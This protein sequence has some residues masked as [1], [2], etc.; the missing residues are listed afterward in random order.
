MIQ[1]N[2]TLR[3][4]QFRNL[5]K[6]INGLMK[7]QRWQEL[8]GE[9][10]KQ[11]TGRLHKLFR[12]INSLFTK[13]EL[14]K[15]L[16]GAAVLLGLS[17]NMQAQD[18]AAPL[19]NP[20]NLAPVI[21]LSIPSLV[22]ID[23]DGDLD[24]FVVEYGYSATSM[25]FFRNEGTAANPVFGK[26]EKN[27]F[28]FA[29]NSEYYIFPAFADLDDDGDQDI[30]SVGYTY[31][32]GV[33]IF[34]H[35]N[36]GTANAPAF[37]PEQTNPFGVQL[38]PYSIQPAMADIDGDGDLDLLIGG[39]RY[40]Y[41]AYEYLGELSYFEN[42]GTPAAAN[43]AGLVST[44]VDTSPV[45]YFVF[46]EFGDLDGDGDMDILTGSYYGSLHYFEN[47]GSTMMPAFGA[48]QT[49]PFNLANPSTEFTLPALGDIDDDGDLDLFVGGYYGNVEFYENLDIDVS[50]DDPEDAPGFNIFPSPAD[51]LLTIEI[52]DT[53][54]AEAQLS[55]F[56]ELG[57][58]V[59]AELVNTTQKTL[60]IGELPA[61]FYIVKIQTEERQMTRKL[62]IQ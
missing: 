4:R 37:G 8:T 10:R 9:Q 2:Y 44:L 56:N 21:D 32:T 27:P 16:A 18:F 29:S 35:E 7:S 62:V 26:P 11:L 57:A 50:I 49:N 41:G 54:F 45:T 19:T 43:F 17:G 13:R 24:M 3:K 25:V 5:S 38:L 47:T 60:D 14:R 39:M 59:K 28:G 34:Y 33:G 52:D 46:P 1:Q 40:D 23:A 42:T 58:I 6:R 12:Q 31:G 55:I 48:V 15:V 53:Q 51:K 30:I 61:G 20:F 22:D 36:T